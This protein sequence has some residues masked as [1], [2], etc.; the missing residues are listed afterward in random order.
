MRCFCENGNIICYH[1]S[2]TEWQYGMITWDDNM[3]R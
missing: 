3:G 2:Y 1:W